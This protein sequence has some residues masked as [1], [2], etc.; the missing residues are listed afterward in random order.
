M[1]ISLTPSLT[2]AFFKG[3]IRQS[4][5][6]QQ[7][8]SVASRRTP[9]DTKLFRFV[10]LKRITLPTVCTTDLEFSYFLFFGQSQVVEHFRISCSQSRPVASRLL[11]WQ[12]RRL[13]ATGG[14]PVLGT[15]KNSDYRLFVC[16][17]FV[18]D[19]IQYGCWRFEF[20]FLIEKFISVDYIQYCTFS[21]QHYSSELNTHACK[22]NAAR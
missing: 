11:V 7:N 15:A 10:E 13:R 5:A 16:L 4:D 17:C 18:D 21:N 19:E 22:Q 20:T 1:P 3:A 14:D 12:C 9:S 2:R 6:T 8:S